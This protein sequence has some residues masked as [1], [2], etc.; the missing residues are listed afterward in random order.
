[1]FYFSKTG[2]THGQPIPVVIPPSVITS[3]QQ[4]PYE[5]Q[6]H[7]PLLQ[8]GFAAPRAISVPGPNGFYGTK[9]S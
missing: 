1:L 7:I 3:L 9:F 6:S 4:Q 2:G 8:P 5:V